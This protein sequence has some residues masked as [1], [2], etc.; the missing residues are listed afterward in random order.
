MI[1]SSSDWLTVLVA[2]V[3][4]GYFITGI[5]EKL[6]KWTNSSLDYDQSSTQHFP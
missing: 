3:V 6:Y 4:I 2:F 1:A 5:R